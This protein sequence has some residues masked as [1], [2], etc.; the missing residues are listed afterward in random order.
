METVG[1]AAFGVAMML[2]ASDP[3]AAVTPIVTKP[4]FV[5]GS[6]ATI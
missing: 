4:L 1:A 5:A 2:I 6:T 3:F